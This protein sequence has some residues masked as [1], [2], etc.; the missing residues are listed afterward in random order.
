MGSLKPTKKG[1]EG[2]ADVGG[3]LPSLAKID[4]ALN[5]SFKATLQP[6]TV[7]IASDS[8]EDQEKSKGEKEADSEYSDE[9]VSAGS[10]AM[11]RMVSEMWL[12]EVR[13]TKDTM[14]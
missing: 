4:Q 5:H 13:E 8:D 10:E 7:T 11:A 9:C 1:P 12:E 3:Q 6:K 2:Q 14:E